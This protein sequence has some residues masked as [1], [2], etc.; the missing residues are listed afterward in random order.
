MSESFSYIAALGLG[1]FGGVHCIGMCGGIMA[2][3]SFAADSSAHGQPQRRRFSL[4]LCYNLGRLF[5]YS[6]MGALVGVLGHFLHA[7][8]G[9]NI[10]GLHTTGLNVPRVIA[11]ILLIAMGLYLANWW[12]GLSYLE[13]AGQRLWR[14]IQPLGKRLLPV[15]TAQQALLLGS[16]W[17][18]LPCGLVYSALA[19]AATAVNPLSAAL[20]MFM[21]GLGT[22]PAVFASGLLA[23]RIKAL[24]LQRQVRLLFACSIMVF[25]V[26]TLI[27]AVSHSGHGSHSAHSTRADHSEHRKGSARVQSEN[28]IME[29]EM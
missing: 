22:L 28:T 6:L 1:F 13:R 10:V 14:Y 23:G 17:G 18:W 5:S 16:L 4:L 11:G 7:V 8:L 29:A 21:F 27:P 24:M 25:G 9:F 12:R 19:Y 20:I 3:L 26:W 2:A 15:V